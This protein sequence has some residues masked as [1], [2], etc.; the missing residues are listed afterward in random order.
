MPKEE[1]NTLK[2]VPN[3]KLALAIARLLKNTL[4]SMPGY[5]LAAP[6]VLEHPKEEINGDFSSNV[7]LVLFKNISPEESIKSP[8]ELAE[9][10]KAKLLES[11]EILTLCDRVEVAGPG[12]LNFYLKNEVLREEL[13]NILS[14][15]EDYGQNERLANQK[16]M[17][18]YT[19][20]NPFKEMH[21]GHLYSNTV[22]ESFARLANASEATVKRANYQ[23]DV[24][25]HVAK[26]IWGMKQKMA[27]ESTSLSD[28][29]K[30]N[31]KERAKFLGQAYALG[32]A[33][34]EDS[35]A[36]KEQIREI[37][38][39]VY[40]KDEEVKEL[41]EKGRA[42]SL[43]YFETIYKRLGTAF[44]FY[45]FESEVGKIGVEYV[46]KHVGTGVF[47]ESEGALIFKGEKFGL[48]T[49]VF[50][51]S[52]GLPTYEAK[53]LG[54]APYKYEQFPYDLS[55]IVTANEVDEYFK[56]VLR[57]LKEI[58]PELAAKTVHISHGVVKLPEGKMSSRTGNIL[59]A[60]WLLNMVKGMVLG[61][62]NEG[63]VLYSPEEKE[64]ISEVVA[65]GAIKYALL[66]SSIGKD[67]IFDPE[68]SLS[69]SG[70]SGPYIQY[71]HARCCSV[72]NKAKNT[73]LSDMGNLKG[74]ETSGQPNNTYQVNEEEVAL[75]RWIYRFPEVVAEASKDFAPSGICTYLFELCQRFNAFYNKHTILSLGSQDSERKGEAGEFRLL[76]TASVAQVLQNGLDLLGIKAPERM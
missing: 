49:R 37:N 68:K 73:D 71:T 61:R 36:V 76:L 11:G 53:D 10:L 52:Q 66:K 57:A 75:L 13:K 32:A 29:E 21:I 7:A 69:L 60:E 30:K 8:R 58:N 19:D 65:V 28:L 4:E 55:I 40:A 18:E 22:G 24:G 9:R 16:V 56:V 26:S 2:L 5:S 23:G 1:K 72:L 15:K 47:E 20:P 74:D 39:K 70:N 6:I 41:Y 34:F 63:E 51:N 31:V 25:M 44:D 45:F 43:K 33:A 38:K 35:E 12:F 62:I 42:W 14:Q 46:K 3:S 54:L 64:E 17:V 50:V 59:T 67:I 48:H 27:E